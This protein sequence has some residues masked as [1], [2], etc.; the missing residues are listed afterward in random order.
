V[1]IGAE[2]RERP[3]IELE[4][5]IRKRRVVITVAERGFRW[6]VMDLGFRSHAERTIVAPHLPMIASTLEHARLRDFRR[7][8]AALDVCAGDLYCRSVGNALGGRLVLSPRCVYMS[9]GKHVVGPSPQWPAS[10]IRALAPDATIYVDR[11]TDQVV[12]AM[13][14]NFRRAKNYIIE[15]LTRLDSNH[16][17]CRYLL[18]P[19]KGQ[20]DVYEIIDR[21]E[22]VTWYVKVSVTGKGLT[23]HS[24]HPPEFPM[25]ELRPTNHE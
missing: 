6:H 10:R 18:G 20:G 12:L 16:Y 11:A 24:F 1:G 2:T 13:G 4:A 7:K 14:W 25:N 22:E 8:C 3:P 5:I 15:Q 17:C 9:L 21:D 19:N 23:V